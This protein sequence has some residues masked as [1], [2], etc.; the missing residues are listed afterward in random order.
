MDT[1]SSIESLLRVLFFTD[2]VGST[3]LKNELGED[4]YLQALQ[5]HNQ[6][7]QE[8]IGGSGG[9]I[10]NFMGD[11]VYACF[12][13]PSQACKAALLLQYKL[14]VEPWEGKPL[15]IRIGFHLG[16]VRE[17]I[18]PTGRANAMGQAADLAA[19]VMDLAQAGQILMT[20]STAQAARAGVKRAPHPVGEGIEPGDAL[21]WIK[22]GLWELQGLDDAVEI[23]EVGVQGV[24][25]L[26]RPTAGRK[27]RPLDGPGS[28]GSGG[29]GGVATATGTGVL[30]EAKPRTGQL[31][32]Q[33]GAEAAGTKTT[34]GA[35]KALLIGGGAAALALA[36]V[37]GAL[38]MK[39]SGP[40]AD[41]GSTGKMGTAPKDAGA[42][43][44]A[45]GGNG[46]G[47]TAPSHLVAWRNLCMDWHDWFGPIYALY[48]EAGR[49]GEL[50]ESIRKS[51]KG[52]LDKASGDV[53]PCRIVDPGAEESARCD[54][55]DLAD[56]PPRF[57]AE[58]NATESVEDA[59]K[60]VNGIR[61]LLVRFP[62]GE[63]LLKRAESWKARGWSQ[64]A[65]ELEQAA[66]DYFDPVSAKRTPG[67]AYKPLAESYT[68]VMTLEEASK[69]IEARF[70][71]LT[72]A[73]EGNERFRLAAQADVVM[74][75]F[76]GFAKEYIASAA[77]LDEMG[78]RAEQIGEVVKK[79]DDSLTRNWDTLDVT[80]FKSGRAAFQSRGGV[81]SVAAFEEFERAMSDR[82]YR[83]LSAEDDPRSAQTWKDLPGA[84]DGIN[85]R[86]T[87]ALKQEPS[88]EL[89]QILARVGRA[90][91]RLANLGPSTLPWNGANEERVRK[92]VGALI[93]EVAGANGEAQTKIA[94]ADA[95]RTERAAKERREALA[96]AEQ[97]RIKK[98]DAE[99]LARE[100]AAREEAAKL[101]TEQERADAAK[102]AEEQRKADEAKAEADRKQR[103]TDA[104]R[105]VRTGYEGMR[106]VPGAAS[107]AIAAAWAKQRA[108]LFASAENAELRSAEDVTRI[109]DRAKSLLAFLKEADGAVPR[110]GEGTTRLATGGDAP[111]WNQD[112]AAA[113][114]AKREA[115]LA[116]ILEKAPYKDGSIEP[117]GEGS[118]YLASVKAAAAK[119]FGTLSDRA[120]QLSADLSSL[121]AALDGFRLLDEA[122]GANAAAGALY[123]RCASDNFLSES[124]ANG[125]AVAALRD[126]VKR[127][128]EIETS[129]DPDFLSKAVLNTQE[130]PSIR[131]AAWRVLG[132][133]KGNGGLPRNAKELEGWPRLFTEA[134]ATLDQLEDTGRRQVLAQEAKSQAKEGWLRGFERLS[135]GAGIASAL[136][137]RA[138]LGVE[139]AD[140]RSLAP[141]ARFN[142]A[143]ESFKRETADL[144]SPEQLGD[145]KAKASVF[146]QQIETMDGGLASAADVAPWLSE[147]KGMTGEGGAAAKPQ[148]DPATQLG[149]ARKGWTGA[150][151]VAGGRYQSAGVRGVTYTKGAKSIEFVL[152]EPTG[153]M[154]EP[155][156]ISRAEVSLA[157]LTAILGESGTMDSFLK[158]Q[159]ASVSKLDRADALPGP[160]V[161]MTPDKGGS[162]SRRTPSIIKIEAAWDADAKAIPNLR[163]AADDD[164]PMQY[165]SP[166][167][168]L[169]AA[170]VAGCR[171][172]TVAEWRAAVALAERA[173][174]LGPLASGDLSPYNLR[175]TTWGQAWNAIKEKRTTTKKSLLDRD[176][177]WP[178]GGAM[179]P[180][181][182]LE[183]VGANGQ[184]Y[185]SN[186]GLLWFRGTNK[187]AAQ[188]LLGDLIGN[189]AEIVLAAG[190]DLGVDPGP[191]AARAAANGTEAFVAGG[192]ALSAPSAD[193]S[194]AALKAWLTT[195]QRMK[196]AD[197]VKGYPGFSDVGF[198]LVFSASG[199]G[200]S[201][202]SLLA[203]LRDKL[204]ERGYL[205]PS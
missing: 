69:P 202:E 128:R 98:E 152:L 85:S 142:L 132:R 190:E 21:K 40:A 175:D 50:P 83:R 135:D 9:D 27:G 90:K 57:I 17:I 13:T 159:G 116:G 113:L 29:G 19:R 179:S 196:L 177:P 187:A 153:D 2:I 60:V 20:S 109:D 51:I 203:A 1:P 194:P 91:E 84:I 151:A 155:A 144:T 77:G 106:A 136:R 14:H 94:A 4:E 11:G 99:R 6:I 42:S 182:A 126:R 55:R 124:V 170:S 123:E 48:T 165:V 171:L 141:R 145:L 102:R 7:L 195:P 130:R 76:A 163:V 180:E 168:A 28:A 95:D 82:K 108:T 12:T 122:A 189:V 166:A 200:P 56:N 110:P 112:L 133:I 129:T 188:S 81:I 104:L 22:H 137:L 96:R 70:D 120:A 119:D 49:Q 10:R 24:A 198:R 62:Q 33:T 8:V 114:A 15:R 205:G 92:E 75:Q 192:S 191:E 140:L 68:R 105:E 64:P 67:L 139:D 201:S 172:P 45:G 101:K 167:G 156:Y 46:G 148:A 41:S 86:L 158:I 89:E 199:A 80:L 100:Q 160:R 58:G 117:G 111:P 31:H 150:N 5:R 197:Q 174:D 43:P 169:Y 30:V 103:L 161:W 78:R 26:T 63:L 3:S 181:G 65:A 173:G 16:E 107:E 66:R 52:R 61:E 146:V 32:A 59:Y 88:P 134:T 185:T 186:D 73:I 183:K 184:T 162:M 34:R 74:E 147:I 37:G 72:R 204:G 44:N 121:R 54:Y 23:W 178:E 87:E 38:L 18:D 97:E 143:L 176:T 35:P 53:N 93:D 115:L 39:G 71:E 47:P 79:L 131:F 149:P 36:G 127:L 25:P 157:D 138:G 125:Q 154:K 118:A 164:L 193:T